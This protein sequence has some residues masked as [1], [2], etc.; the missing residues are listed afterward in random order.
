MWEYNTG[1]DTKKLLLINNDDLVLFVGTNK[2]SIF[3]LTDEVLQ[4]QQLYNPDNENKEEE[5]KEEIKLPSQTESEARS[6]ETTVK[7]SPKSEKPETSIIKNKNTKPP[8]SNNKNNNIRQTSVPASNNKNNNKP[9][10][11]NDDERPEEIDPSPLESNNN[12][13]GSNT[14]NG[15]NSNNNLN[16]TPPDNTN[17]VNNSGNTNRENNSS[18]P[19]EAAPQQTPV[20]SPEQTPN[21][22]NPASP[23]PDD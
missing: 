8:A 15:S 14:S 5:T 2:A 6:E 13:D 9:A 11:N 20:Q 23:N 18:P 10:E 16:Q 22:A 3:R 12:I 19:I 17:N 7:V 1:Q 4:N 21:E